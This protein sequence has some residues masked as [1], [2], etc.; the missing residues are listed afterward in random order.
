MSNKPNFNAYAIKD[1]GR[2]KK[3]FWTKIGGAV[4]HEKGQ[5][6]TIQLDALPIDG[7]IILMPPK[8]EDD[9]NA[10]FEAEVA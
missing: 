6:L 4:P 2:G 1:A 7:R 9:T 10:T 8:P 3:S 5:G